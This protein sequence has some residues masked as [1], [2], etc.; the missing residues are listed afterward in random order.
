MLTIKTLK[1]KR[2]RTGLVA[3]IAVLVLIIGTL[4]GSIIWYNS[5]LKPVSANAEAR[6]FVV[7]EGSSAKI[8]AENLK[9]LNLIKSQRA[10]L[11]YLDSKNYKNKLQAGTYKFSGAMSSQQIA[12]KLA[13][14]DVDTNWLTILPGKRLDQIKQ[15]FISSGYS[16]SEVNAAFDASNYKDHTLLANAPAGATLEGLLYPDSFQKDNN[17]PASAIVREAMDELESKI[18]PEI[19]NGFAVQGLNTYQGIILASIVLQESGSSGVQP[20][21]AQVFLSRL[22]Q[23]MMLG[24]DVTAFYASALAGISPSVQ[25]NSPYNTRIH[26]GLPPGP[27]GNV[28]ESAL[29]AVAQPSNTDYLFFVAGDDGVVHFSYTEA[30]HEAAIKQYCKQLCQ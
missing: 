22:K 28:N 7:D 18:T 10:F 13:R 16:S 1:F 8:I 14:G 19:N 30:E 26:S 12:L 23:G 24:S 25:I 4:F 2:H 20:T 3:F 9:A 15:E 27:I 11:F 5:S 17:T 29:G 21:V 6:L